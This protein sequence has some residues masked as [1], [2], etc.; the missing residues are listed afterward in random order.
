MTMTTPEDVHMP[1]AGHGDERR[2]SA[3]R[4]PA[5]GALEISPDLRLKVE[6]A[7]AAEVRFMKLCLYFRLAHLHLSKF[8]LTAK[9]A[10]LNIVGSLYR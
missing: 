10:L 8:S 3:S 1:S 7:L 4:D 5:L 6:K 9:C 2:I